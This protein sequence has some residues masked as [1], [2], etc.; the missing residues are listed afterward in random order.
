MGGGISREEAQKKVNDAAREATAQ[1][2]LAIAQLKERVTPAQAE[3]MA[4]LA[5]NEAVAKARAEIEQMMGQKM[6]T[7]DVEKLVQHTNELT[8]MKIEAKMEEKFN[9]VHKEIQDVQ[10]QVKQHGEEM[11]IMW[12]QR[13]QDTKV[14]HSAIQANTEG[15]KQ[16][17]QLQGENQKE[18]NAKFGMLTAEIAKDRTDN[19]EKFG[20]IIENTSKNQ[21]DTNE[22]ILALMAV[23][24]DKSKG[25]VEN[26]PASKKEIVASDVID[27]STPSAPECPM[28]DAVCKLLFC[29][30]YFCKT[31]H[32]K[33]GK[34]T[35][36]VCAKVY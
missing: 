16:M 13:E 2:E 8:T 4:K 32:R 12:K 22:K 28:C 6:S 25:S 18:N 34:I 36:P 23:M 33:D 21:A 24:T 29:Q 26:H 1:H 35:C 31:C 3:A 17:I 20:M 15:I 9:V 10:A 27:T 30:H 14:I 19:N 7:D 5:A 11:K